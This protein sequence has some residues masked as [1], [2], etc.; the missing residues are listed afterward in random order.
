MFGVQRTCV[1]RRAG[2]KTTS[3][4]KG[5]FQ[6]KQRG[7]L[8][9]SRLRAPWLRSLPSSQQPHNPC[10]SRHPSGL[11]P[12][13]R[14]QQQ[15]CLLLPLRAQGVGKIIISRIYVHSGVV[16]HPPASCRSPWVR[17][18]ARCCCAP[19][20]PRFAAPPAAWPAPQPATGG[21]ARAVRASGGWWWLLEARVNELSL[22]RPPW[23][24]FPCHPAG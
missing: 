4:W 23:G 5:A 9:G 20:P 13:T 10:R 14:H 19:S 17:P 3:G 22:M 2:L 8:I 21:P 11:A 16:V 15:H 7:S 6:A 18:A 12:G 1:R 24:C